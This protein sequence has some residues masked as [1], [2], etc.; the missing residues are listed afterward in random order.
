[1]WYISLLLTSVFSQLLV[2]TPQPPAL[3]WTLFFLPKILTQDN[4]II[5]SSHE[6]W[7]SLVALLVKN[8]PAM[9]ET[10]V[11]D[12]GL[13]PGEGKG[14]PLQYSDLD[15]FMDCIVHGV[16]KESDMTKQLRHTEGDFVR[17]H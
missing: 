10:W 6:R 17:N 14:C 2:L 8:L 12:L 15:N 9:Q 3:T 4:R 5:S 1:V 13:I 7:A 16:A 11:G